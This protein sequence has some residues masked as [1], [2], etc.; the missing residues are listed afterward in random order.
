MIISHEHRFIFVKTLKTA[1]TSIEVALAPL[2]G[3]HDIVTPVW[4]EVPGHR[5]RNYLPLRHLLFPDGGPFARMEHLRA[6]QIRDRF[7]EAWDEYTTFAVERNPWEK[8]VS[9][10]YFHRAEGFCDPDLPLADY[11]AGPGQLVGDH[12]HYTDGDE[13]IVDHLLRFEDLDQE[14]PRLSADLG[15]PLAGLGVRAKAGIRPPDDDHRVHYD[16]ATA[17]LVAERHAWA[18]ERLGYRF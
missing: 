18:I 4:P 2:C 6:V 5:P 13:L 16:P 3:D 12:S 7:P 8:V 10:W 11:V 14:L 9:A 15:L 17:A 1:G